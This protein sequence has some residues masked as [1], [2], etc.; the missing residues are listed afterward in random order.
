MRSRPRTLRWV[1]TAVLLLVTATARAQEPMNSFPD[2][3]LSV[4][5]LGDSDIPP[6]AHRLFDDI[7]CTCGQCQ[8]MKL[9]ECPCGFAGEAR[10]EIMGMLRGKDI[11]TPHKEEAAFRDIRQAF[12]ARYGK[13]VSVSSREGSSVDPF[14]YLLIF[15]AVS[16]LGGFVYIVVTSRK[17]QGSR[18]AA[19][20]RAGGQRRRRR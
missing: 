11:S 10:E 6:V 8:H 7:E 13:Q 9:S 2:G 16:T 3:G 15:L 5:M 4:E 1:L 17:P 20:T 12:I 19:R 14:V 18:Q